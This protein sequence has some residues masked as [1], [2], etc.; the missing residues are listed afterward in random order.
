MEAPA[1]QDPLTAFIRHPLVLPVLL[2]LSAGLL[3]YALYLVFIWVP[4]EKIMGPVQRIFYFHVGA[5]ISGYCAIAILLLGSLGFFA[6]GKREW[7]ALAIS[8]GEVGFNFCTI[9]LLSGMIWG[10]AAWQTWFNWEPRLVSFLILWLVFLGYNLLRIFGHPLKVA[11]H[12]AVLG[13]VGAVTVPIMVYS[14]RLLPQVAQLHPVV[15]EK[16]GLAPEMA[17][18]LVWTLIALVLFQLVLIVMR[19]RLE[20]ISR[21]LELEFN[22]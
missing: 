11:S 1:K 2:L 21:Q 14:I 3:S 17:Y 4:N 19:A 16:Q 5:A 15:I 10:H 9:V 8:G 12:A 20:L 7:D 18:T 22:D 6:T 13:I